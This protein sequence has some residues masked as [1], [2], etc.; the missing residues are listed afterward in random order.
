VP[1]SLAPAAGAGR[2]AVDREAT[3]EP[4]RLAVWPR[5]LAAACLAA[6]FVGGG[7]AGGVWLASEGRGADALASLPGTS[8]DRVAPSPDGSVA[9]QRPSTGAPRDGASEVAGTA[10]GGPDPRAAERSAGTTPTGLPTTT[11][12]SGEPTAEPTTPPTSEPAETE[13][14]TGQGKG[15]GPK[16]PKPTKSD[17][18]E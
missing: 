15:R 4:E 3:T 7:V 10:T 16:K 17:D 1:A 12:T 18:T 13:T 9:A 6:A 5:R 14:E 11:P 2:R 8:D